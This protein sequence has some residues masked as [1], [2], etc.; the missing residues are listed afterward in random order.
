M[1]EQVVES[2]VIQTIGKLQVRRFG[3]PNRFHRPMQASL[4]VPDLHGPWHPLLMVC[5]K[6]L[7]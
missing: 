7:S 6:M 1:L 5:T 2:E 4:L 3:V